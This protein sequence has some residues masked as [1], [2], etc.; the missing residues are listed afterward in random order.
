MAAPITKIQFADLKALAD[1]ANTK[2][3]PANPYSFTA[4]A[5]PDEIS[6]PDTIIAEAAY[7]GAGQFPD[8]SKVTIRIYVYKT[9][10]GVKKYSGAF[11]RKAFTGT[12]GAGDFSMTWTW[13][14]AT[15]GPTAPDGYIAVIAAPFFADGLLAWIDHAVALLT[16]DGSFSN[17][18]WKFDRTLDAGNLGFPAQNLPCGRGAWLK[19]LN[20]I[21]RDL[22]AKMDVFGGSDITL[23]DAKKVSGPWCVSVAPNCYLKHSGFT[24]YK[25]LRFIYSEADSPTGNQLAREAEM[26]PAYIGVVNGAN[27]FT[28]DADVL[29]NGEIKIYSDPGEVF[30]DWVVSASHPGIAISFNPNDFQSDLPGGMAVSSFIFTFTNVQFTVGTPVVLT[31]TPPSGHSV[32]QPGNPSGG[33]GRVNAVFTESDKT[34]Y[35]SADT[36]AIHGGS[37]TV[38]AGAAKYSDLP[39]ALTAI[40]LTDPTGNAIALESHHRCFCKGVFTANTLP[41]PGGMTY[42]DVDMPQYRYTA[43]NIFASSRRVARKAGLPYE[44]VVDN[45]GCLYP[46][47]RDLDYAPDLVAGRP[48]NGSVAWQSALASK[49]LFNGSYTDLIPA[50]HSFDYVTFVAIDATDVRFFANDPNVIIFAKAGAFP[51]P[52]D[53]DI[54]GPGGAWLSLK[55][56]L[57]GFARDTNWF[58]II[59]NP[60]A[61]TIEVMNANVVIGLPQA[62]NG[63]FFATQIDDGDNVFPELEHSSYHFFDEGFAQRPIPLYGYCIYK[64]TL[65]R[66]PVKNTSGIAVSPNAGTADLPVKIG[67]MRGFSFDSAGVFN[68]LQTVI[69]PAGQASISV[70]VFLPVLQGWPL[71]YQAASA[72]VIMA[73]VNFQPMMHSSF[74]N[75]VGTFNGLDRSIGHFAGAPVDT[76]SRA[77]LFFNGGDSSEPILL[78][79]AAVVYNDL[80][81]L[82]ALL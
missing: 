67:L 3:L 41:T 16:E 47:Y 29:I 46:I 22:F 59:Y 60:T 19:M 38:N 45:L 79:I 64:L 18:A 27:N 66:Q 10:G 28:W 68:E 82:L 42:L 15:P 70:D 69:I 31:C 7:G 55:D 13:P 73:A 77:L 49:Y 81:A 4:L 9:I 44:A 12:P 6:L 20:T 58:Y 80:M 63:S 71:A 37:D 17:P 76:S 11:T 33:G 32:I 53:Y 56:S 1:L 23:N 36:L 75:T 14:A 8:G 72:V 78:P 43:G 25:N 54:T 65:R 26:L 2:L 30:A 48:I 34:E 35:T 52:S 57:P 39:A 74:T 51:T 62:P 40:T 21:W 61:A 50:N 24:L 5:T